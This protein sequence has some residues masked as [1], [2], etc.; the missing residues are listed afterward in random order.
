MINIMVYHLFTA[1]DFGTSFAC[2]Y[3]SDSTIPCC[4]CGDG[5]GCLF[6]YVFRHELLIPCS[7]SSVHNALQSLINCF[8]SNTDPGVPYTVTVRAST[9]VGIGEPVSIVVFSVQQGKC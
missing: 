2:V 6:V 7:I 1:S 9:A 5:G 3:V 8:C 4:L